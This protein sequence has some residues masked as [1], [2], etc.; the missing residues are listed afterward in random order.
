MERNFPFL[1]YL[2]IGL[3]TFGIVETYSWI[4]WLIWL[5]IYPKIELP[6][7]FQSRFVYGFSF[8]SSFCIWVWVAP[9]WCPIIDPFYL[10]NK[11]FILV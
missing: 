10:S 5:M 11:N 7:G 4:S 1:L 6:F 3:N 9:P 8:L 2:K